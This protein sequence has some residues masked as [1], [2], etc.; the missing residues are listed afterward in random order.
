MD[1]RFR[2]NDKIISHSARSRASDVVAESIIAALN[3]TNHLP[4]DF[5][6]D[7][8]RSKRG[9]GAI[10]KLLDQHTVSNATNACLKYSKFFSWIKTPRSYQLNSLR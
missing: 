2:G 10:S 5:L 4:C 6:I 8:D 1:F 3:T 9:S 7:M